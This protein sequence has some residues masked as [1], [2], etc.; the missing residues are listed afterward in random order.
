[1]HFQILII[2]LFLLKV[3]LKFSPLERYSTSVLYIENL[4]PPMGRLMRR[5]GGLFK[6]ARGVI[7]VVSTWI[8]WLNTLRRAIVSQLLLVYTPFHALDKKG[9]PFLRYS[10]YH[11]HHI[12]IAT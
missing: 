9:F 6:L 5:H 1:M 3:N 12:C 10:L 4:P 8:Q 2:E 7:V 11:Y